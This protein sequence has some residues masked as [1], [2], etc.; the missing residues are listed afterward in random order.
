MTPHPRS[1]NTEAQSI[2]QALRQLGDPAIAAHS[3]RFFKTGP[4]QYGEGDQFLGI[5]LPM[6]RSLLPRYRQTSLAAM[7]EVLHSPWH[8]E[9]LFAL[10]LMVAR[11]A[12]GD[13]DDKAAVFA[14]YLDNIACINNWDLVDCSAPQIVGAFL[15]DKDR[16]LLGS[17]ANSTS[18]WERRIAVIATLHLIKNNDFDDCLAVA[19]LLLADRHDLIHKAVG[20]MLREV[21]KRD[22]E[23]A[24]VFLRQH[25][26]AMPR[27]MLRSAIEKFPEPL[28]QAY[29]H[30]R[31]SVTGP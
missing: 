7:C 27:T 5:R 6:L 26:Q 15:E 25:Y 16:A 4:G 29:L 8:E 12:K 18:L 28:R 1:T 22:Q 20:W 2:P 14:S 17:L 31:I 10:L 30:N 19:A 3:Q 11:F 13:Q 24:E 21:G 23:T 9:R